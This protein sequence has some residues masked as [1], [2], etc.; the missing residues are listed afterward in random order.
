[1]NG[2]DFVAD[3]N[4]LISLHEGKSFTRPFLDQ[5]AAV[6]VISEIELLGWS[7]IGDSEKR[8]L[9][10]LINDCVMIDLRTEIKSIAI[11]LRQKQKI[12]VPDA[13]IAAT[14]LYLQ[15]PIVTSD[16]GFKNIR[17]I[18]LILIS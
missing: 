13:I 3:T 4:F 12:K 6:S 11:M 2:I 7:K 8:K 16:H 18:E 15:V 14:S 5:V 17:D 9:Q 10:A 1:M